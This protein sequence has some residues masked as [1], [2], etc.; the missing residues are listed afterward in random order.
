MQYLLDLHTHT[1]ASGHA[2]NTISE[3][4]KAAA[5]KGLEL[6]GITEHAVKMPGTC[7][8]FYFSNL[9]AVERKQYGIQ[10][11]MG[12]ELNV[13]DYEGKVDLGKS[14]LK[15][16]DLCVASFHIPCIAPGTM[17]ENTHAACCVMENPYVAILGHPDDGRFPFDYE[18][19][20]Q[21]AKETGTILELNNNSLSPDSFRPN[22]RENDRRMLE[23]CKKYGVEVVVDSDAHTAA[24]IGNH[25][26]AEEVLLEAAFP[27]ELLLNDKPEK[28]L[29][30]I[31]KKKGGR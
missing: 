9:K 6:L 13:I 15:E 25:Q 19:L 8:L 17:E 20:V 26:Y 29:E 1:L 31:Y 2:F 18:K 5:E 21:K 30:K 24:Q 12:A 7:H 10:L 16:M 14:M 27:E 4:A 23:L 11:L 28:I 22:T 3:M